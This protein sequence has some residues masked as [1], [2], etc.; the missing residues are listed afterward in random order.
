MRARDAIAQL[1]E[2][3]SSMHKLQAQCPE[4]HKFDAGVQL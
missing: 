1:I 3:L 4:L 2:C